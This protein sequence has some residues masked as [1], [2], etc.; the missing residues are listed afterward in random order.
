MKNKNTYLSFQEWKKNFFKLKKK[1]LQKISDKW[2]V[3]QEMYL[4]IQKQ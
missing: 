4:K 2:G 1:R 3:S